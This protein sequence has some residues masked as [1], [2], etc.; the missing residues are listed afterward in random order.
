[1]VKVL[2]YEIRA[3]RDCLSVRFREETQDESKKNWQQV[4]TY[5]DIYRAINGIINFEYR[6]ML[7]SEPDQDLTLSEAVRLYEIVKKRIMDQIEIPEPGEQPRQT[8]S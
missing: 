3:D 8:P 2:S 6:R 7:L 4:G 1:M 5:V